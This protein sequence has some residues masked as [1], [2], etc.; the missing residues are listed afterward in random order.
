[1]HDPFTNATCRQPEY[2]ADAAERGGFLWDHRI[3]GESDAKRLDRY[4]EAVSLCQQC[5]N[6][7][8]GSCEREHAWVEYRYGE[9]SGVWAGVVHDPGAPNT[10]GLLRL[11]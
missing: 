4:R 8:D 9:H 11:I 1:M 7:I 10:E 2:R 6:L 5:P 3:D